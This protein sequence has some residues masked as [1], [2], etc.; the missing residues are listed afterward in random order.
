MLVKTL[1]WRQSCDIDALM[2]EEFDP[3]VF[4]GPSAHFYRKDREGRP[5][6]YNESSKGHNNHKIDSKDIIRYVRLVPN[7][8]ISCVNGT[9]SPLRSKARCS[10]NGKDYRSTRLHQCGSGG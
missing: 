10:V 2:K 7:Y 9:I 5:V 8:P 6:I 1:R 3:K 4:G